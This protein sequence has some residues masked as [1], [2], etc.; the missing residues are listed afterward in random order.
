M[1]AATLLAGAIALT[2][3]SAHPADT[4][5]A[6]DMKGFET[7]LYQGKWYKKKWEYKSQVHHAKRVPLQLSGSEQVIV[8]ERRVSVP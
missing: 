8:S 4:R 7:S 3:M 5:A 1:I 2:P 6:H